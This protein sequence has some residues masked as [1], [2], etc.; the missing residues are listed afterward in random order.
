MSEAG[1]GKGSGNGSFPRRKAVTPPAGERR[2][3]EGFRGAL[4]KFDLVMK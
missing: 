3:T 4:P 2:K 1:Q